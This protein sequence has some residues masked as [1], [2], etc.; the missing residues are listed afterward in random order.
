MSL[1]LGFVWKVSIAAVLTSMVFCMYPQ[2]RHFFLR[3]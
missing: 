1:L 2:I 3:Q